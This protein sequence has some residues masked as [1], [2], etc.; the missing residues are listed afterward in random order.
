MCILYVTKTNEFSTSDNSNYRLLVVATV[1]HGIQK[2]A[3]SL[4]KDNY[5][6]GTPFYFAISTIIYPEQTGTANTARIVLI[7]GTPTVAVC[8]LVALVDIGFRS[9]SP[10]G[11]FFDWVLLRVG[12][13]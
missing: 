12:L 13:L 4:R 8:L 6:A 7:A 9:H 2:D 1:R 3:W 5:Y 10:R 11:G